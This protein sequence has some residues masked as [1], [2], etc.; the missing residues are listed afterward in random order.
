[1]IRIQAWY[2]DGRSSRR[3]SVEV[4]VDQAGTVHLSGDDVR[5]TLPLSQVRV[6]TRLGNT[7]R[8]LQFPDG[9]KCET[10][11]ND[12]VDQVLEHFDQGR[13]GRWLHRLESRFVYVAVAVAITAGA[14]WWGI[15]DGVPALA[16]QVAFALPE[17][18]DRAM[19]QESLALLDRA[20]F[21]PTELSEAER[22]RLA[23]LFA[24]VAD[25]AA[26][27]L[28][29]ELRSSPALGANALALPSG[30]VV[31]TDGL[32]DLAAND[33]ELLAVLAHEVGHI[34]YRHSV[35]ML[36][37]NSATALIVATV[38]GDLSSISALS[39]ALPTL[40]VQAHYSRD[41]EREADRYAAEWLD[42][43]GIPRKHFADL[44]R[45]LAADH[46]E[47]AED[48]EEGDVIGYIGSHPATRERI[49]ALL[50]P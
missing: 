37:Q 42:R 18:V 27:D 16:R 25:G 26:P 23:G 47:H 28:R 22:E 44:L 36:L 49:E 15:V 10:T 21:E 5:L 9:S 41:F 4:L 45:R 31:V 20:L 40:L 7:P 24:Q 11:D 50:E 48:E 39:A 29:L 14:L 43:N 13:G 17:E 35:R 32:A 8:F 34:E 19:G 6:S 30:I 2:Y 3:Q 33:E 38:T 12:T 1:M 46:G